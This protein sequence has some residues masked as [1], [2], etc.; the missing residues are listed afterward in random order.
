MKVGEF[1]EKVERIRFEN[2]WS[3]DALASALGLS[4]VMLFHLRKGTHVVS[5]KTL[6][7]LTE[8]D[9]KSSVSSDSRKIIHEISQRAQKSRIRVTEADIVRGN[10]EA[11]VEY[12][13][14]D[15]P[16]EFPSHVRLTRPVVSDGARLISDLILNED[17]D[18]ILLKTLPPKLAND[19]FLNSLSPFCYRE[20]LIAAMDLVF[21]LAWKKR[22]PQPPV[23]KRF[24]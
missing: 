12:L 13:V 4:R 7:R 15:K 2:R 9:R 8:L 22:L 16:V 23:Q 20:L 21:G 10:M 18:T 19:K 17:Y 11:E 5:D 6:K 24:Q 1:K 3:W 14:R